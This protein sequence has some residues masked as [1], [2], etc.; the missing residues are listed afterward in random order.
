[1]DYRADHVAGALPEVFASLQ[2]CN[3]EPF[4]TSYGSDETTSAA[5]QALCSLFGTTPEDCAIAFVSTGTAANCIALSCIAQ[6]FSTILC[7]KGAHLHTSECNA[8]EF[9]SGAK[10]TLLEQHPDGRIKSE[11]LKE[12][13]EGKPHKYPHEPKPSALSIT[14]PTE[15][16]AVY[17]VEEVRSLCQIA[18]RNGL[19]VHMDGARIAN[20]VAKFEDRKALI[21]FTKEAG[22]RGFDIWW[23]W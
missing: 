19:K 21:Q 3:A 16:G 8:P 7:A 22:G 1:M 5:K 12:L 14:Q 20:A 23:L 6:P 4:A 15:A 2:N 13:V 18:K 10:L 9:F 11:S 17:S